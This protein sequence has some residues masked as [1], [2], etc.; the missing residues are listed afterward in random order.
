MRPFLNWIKDLC[1]LKFSSLQLGIKRV[2]TPTIIQMQNVECGAA[3]LA[4]I[5][6]YYKL[7]V[8]LAELRITCGV[9]R[10]GTSIK[11][12]ANAAETFGL[13][14][15]GRT[16]EMEDL[17]KIPLPSIVYWNFNHYLVFEGMD[18]N[19]IYLNDPAGGPKR[20]THEVFDEGFTGYVLTF[21]PTPKFQPKGEPDSFQNLLVRRLKGFY[22]PI[23]FLSICKTFLL[24]PWFFIPI[25]IQ[26][27]YDKVLTT[28]NAQAG[29]LLIGLL[30][31]VFI[32]TLLLNLFEYNMIQKLFTKMTITSTTSFFWHILKLPLLFFSQRSTGEIAWRYTLNEIVSSVLSSQFI[33]LTINILLLVFY[34]Y[35]IFLFSG[36]I[37]ILALVLGLLNVFLFILINRSRNDAFTAMQQEYGKTVGYAYSLLRSIE[38]IKSAGNEMTS[39]GILSGYYAK[40]TNA[41]FNTQFKTLILTIFPT[42]S[43]QVGKAALLAIGALQILNGELTVGMLISL[44]SFFLYLM[45]PIDKLMNV[46]S[47][48]QTMFIDIKRLNDVMDNTPETLFERPKCLENGASLENLKG[49]VEFIDVSFGFSKTEG[50][51]IKN[52]NLKLEPGKRIGLVGPVSSG[53]TTIA[54]LAAGLY[55]PWTGQI[56]YD[57]KPIEE[58]PDEVFRSSISFV[59]SSLFFFEETI[60]NNLTFWD[61]LVSEEDLTK[62]CKD[63]C[64][65][66]VIMKRAKGYE[67]VI[68]EGGTV[69]SGGQRQ[70]LE[71]ARGLAKNPT[72]LITDEVSSALDYK[73]EATISLNLRKRGCASIIIAQRLAT[74]K[75]CDEII[76]LDK[77]EIVQRGTHQEL[78]LQGGYFKDSIL[79]EVVE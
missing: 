4:I 17:D 24:L 41:S 39:F 75:D 28:S 68:C 33:Y 9:T 32:V 8:P 47:Q 67:N 18:K 64:I 7:F 78:M 40:M 50:P 77:G 36:S 27:F 45:T 34:L 2:R 23:V 48:L 6:G 65:H 55:R 20:V 61:E 44:Q 57:G 62:S 53:K 51:R 58:I 76:V 10:D 63:A 30:L 60:K 56:L 49:Y 43:L 59:D 21:E 31:A 26:F 1:R 15:E 70:R 52:I 3:A 66:D 42:V 79:A 54:R 25:S 37:G 74:V 12:I 72:V 5:L 19:F 46:S 22:K 69:F 29:Y 16:Y 14:T 11:D 35:I 73:T 71:I 13:K 38:G